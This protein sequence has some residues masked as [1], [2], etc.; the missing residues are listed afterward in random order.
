MVETKLS[1]QNVTRDDWLR[2]R[3]SGLGGSD[4]G[5]VCGLNPYSSPLQVFCDKTTEEVQDHDNESMRQGR[6]LEEYVAKR[7]MEETGKKVR[8]SNFMYR[9][10]E[11][12]FM[13]ADVDRLI[14]GEDAGLECKTA[15]AYNADKWKDGKIP[16]H[17]I[18]PVLPLYGCNRKKELVHC[19]RYFRQEFKYAKSAGMMR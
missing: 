8:R 12:P 10:E 18:Y 19:C 7:F 4:A 14:V 3:K 15:N 1:L 17:Y 16:A 13:I 11:H 6:D 2:L 5:A 9:S